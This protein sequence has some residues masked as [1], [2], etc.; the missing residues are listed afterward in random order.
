MAHTEVALT[1]CLAMMM[2]EFINDPTKAPNSACVEGIK[3]ELV[4]VD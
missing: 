2:H 3:T 4:L 1:P